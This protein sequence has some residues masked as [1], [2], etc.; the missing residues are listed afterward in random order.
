MKTR[1][2]LGSF[3][4]LALAGGLRA[5]LIVNLTAPVVGGRHVLYGQPG[6]TLFFGFTVNNPD[7]SDYWFTGSSLAPDPGAFGLYTDLI[8]PCMVQAGSTSLTC[9]DA[10][11]QPQPPP[12]GIGSFLISADSGRYEGTLTVGWQAALEE[13]AT[14][15][16]AVEIPVPPAGEEA[17]PEPDTLALLGS[18]LAAL[19]FRRRRQR[20]P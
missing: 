2:I 13:S 19:A 1:L 12:F 11:G 3:I 10:G 7:S 16:V 6:D 4:V 8:W 15:D 18:G 9:L 5:G 20:Q 17:I 14:F